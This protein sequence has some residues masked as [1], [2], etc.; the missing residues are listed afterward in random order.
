MPHRELPAAS[1]R[2]GDVIPP[3][4]EIIEVRVPELRRLFNAIDPSPFNDRDL[5]PGAEEFIVNWASEISPSK[6]LGLIVYVG[7][8]PGAA[9]EAAALREAIRQFFERKARLTRHR[10]RELFGRGRV[11]LAI[12]LVFLGVTS[13]LGRALGVAFAGAAGSF[14]QESLI[15]GGWVAMWR[16]LELFLYDWWPIRAEAQR[17]DRLAAMPVAIVYAG[18]GAPDAWRHDWPSTPAN[19]SAASPSGISTA[20]I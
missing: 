17:Y 8:Q 11:S 12:G 16:P 6:P 1:A 13:V 10:L 20:R 19:Q 9:D 7:R 5:D 14:L 2:V 18:E 4:S 15:I 3:G